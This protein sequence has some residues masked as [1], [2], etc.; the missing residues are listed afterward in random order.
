MPLTELPEL[1]V[2]V[3]ELVLVGVSD[4]DGDCDGVVV[5]EELG[6]TPNDALID[7]ET[8]PEVP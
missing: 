5:G 8:A 1:N 2:V 6:V 4:G 7:G 3:G